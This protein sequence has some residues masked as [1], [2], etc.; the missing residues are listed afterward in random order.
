MSN[1]DEIREAI[2]RLFMCARRECHICR[3]KDRPKSEL[4]S[5][6]CIERI[7]KNM[8][9]LADEYLKKNKDRKV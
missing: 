9:I 4:P 6:D 7:N 5:D 2:I 8:K 3:Y 1:Q